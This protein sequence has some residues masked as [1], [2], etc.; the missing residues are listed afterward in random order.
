M[1]QGPWCRLSV[2]QGNRRLAFLNWNTSFEAVKH[3]FPYLFGPSVPGCTSRVRHADW[4]N[5]K[6]N[7][8]AIQSNKGRRQARH[9]LRTW[10]MLV[11]GIVLFSVLL[12]HIS[13]RE[14]ATILSRAD[15]RYLCAAI[16]A[17]LAATVFR[18]IR[19]GRFFPVQGRWLKLYGA[20]AFIR[21]INFV[22]PFRSGEVVSLGM[23]K[24]HQLSPSIA[25]TAPVWLLLR[26]TDVVALSIW[27]AIVLGILSFPGRFD[28]KVQW[29]GWVLMVISVGL[30]VA[31]VCL[32]L[33]ASRLRAKASYSWLSQRLCAFKVGLDR[34]CGIRVFLRTM[35]LA[36]L[37]WGAIVMVS[38]FAQLTFDTPLN[39]EDSLLASVA[40]LAISLLPIH[41]PLAIGTIDAAWVGVMT[42]LGVDPPLAIG[43]AIGVRLVIVSLMII[44]GLLGFFLLLVHANRS[45]ASRGRTG[46]TRF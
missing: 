20:F 15:V 17:G 32:P 44:D 14:L 28:E 18:T 19:Y 45:S 38:I 22:L 26:V 8:G 31:M 39:L 27:V 5:N 33:W 9:Q 36:V 13:L 23:L 29:A 41:A 42:M 11:I 2:A 40:V 25:E 34:V 16:F 46:G 30:V 35:F 6:A 3:R 12:S 10:M 43:L 1:V 24:Q 4:A 21:L 37:I 7:S